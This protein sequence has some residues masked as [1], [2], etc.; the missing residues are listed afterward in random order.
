M[1]VE[2]LKKLNKDKKLV[3][4]LA[5]KHDA[6]QAS[7]TIFK[8]IPRLLGPGLSKARKFPTMIT[9]NENMMDKIDDIKSAIKFQMKKVLCLNVAAGH[10][11]MSEEELAQNVF[12]PINTLVSLLQ[13]NWQNALLQ[14]N[15]QNVRSLYM[16]STM[17]KVQRLY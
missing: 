4:M 14:K 3:K 16:K 17:G 10:V 12:L 11:E 8:Q 9:H 7:D 15:W 5:K 13:K 2:S 1:D 6:F